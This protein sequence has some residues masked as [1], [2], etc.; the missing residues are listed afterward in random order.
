M[1]APSRQHLNNRSNSLCKELRSLGDGF[2]ATFDGPARAAQCASSVIEAVRSLGIDV[3]AG[4]HTGE[5]ELQET[6][7]RGVA[8]HI[9]GQAAAGEC[10]VSR[11]VKGLVAGAELKFTE[12]E[13]TT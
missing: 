2:L 3:R 8:V 11:T 12:R 5:V 10:L 4:V 9:A 13:K 6:G 1:S 7:V